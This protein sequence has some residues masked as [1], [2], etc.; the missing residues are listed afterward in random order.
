MSDAEREA[1]A[2]SARLTALDYELANAEVRAPVDGTV[3]G[4]NIFTRGGV[5]GPGFRLMDLVPT[6]DPLIVEG[7]LPVNLVDKIHPGLQVDLIFSAFNANSTP[8]IPGVVTQVSA[9]RTVDERSGAAYYKMKAKVTPEGAKLIAA[10][11]LDIRSGMPV[12]LFV[13]TG[14]RTMMSYLL[15]PIFDRAK[16]SMTEE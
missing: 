15:K 14:E 12:E 5:V 11:K 7:Q 8:H 13:K 2:L 16:T 1:E 4:L 10:K 6:D 9:D 3:V